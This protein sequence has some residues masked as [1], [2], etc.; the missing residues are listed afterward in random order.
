MDNATVNGFVPA[1]AHAHD[2]KEEMLALRVL[3]TL[4]QRNRCV[5]LC[6]YEED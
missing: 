2:E 5:A 3:A 4:K 6:E 1:G